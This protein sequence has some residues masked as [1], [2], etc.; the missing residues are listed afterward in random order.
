MRCLFPF[1]NKSKSRKRNSSPEFRNQNSSNS[2]NT[3]VNRATK[4]AGSVPS[5]RSLPEMYKERE[6][7]LRVFSFSELRAATNDFNKLLKIGEGGFGRVY[8]GTIRSPN[9]EEGE[10][11]VVAI[12]KLNKHGLQVFFPPKFFDRF[13]V[14]IP[15]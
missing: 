9:G 6:H 7:N 11:T 3:A 14:R 10:P 2:D 12:K 4:S 8:K 15:F 1:K 13:Y 5:P